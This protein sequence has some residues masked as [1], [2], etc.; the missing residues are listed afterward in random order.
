MSKKTEGG[1]GSRQFR[2][3]PNK[4]RIFPF[5]PSLREA[6]HKKKNYFLFCEV[7]GSFP[8]CQKA[9]LPLSLN[10]VWKMSKLKH[11]VPQQVWTWVC[12][13]QP[14]PPFGQ[15]LNRKKRFCSGMAF[16]IVKNLVEEKFNFWQRPPPHPLENVWTEKKIFFQ[17]GFPNC[18]KY[19]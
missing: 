5:L 1:G 17:E 11:K 15:C 2:Q 3:C 16:L 10:L 7:F 12:K 14:P 19:C 13:D 9:L 8:C 18:Y 6:S 4:S